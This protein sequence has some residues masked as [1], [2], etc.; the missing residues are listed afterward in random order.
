M[1]HGLYWPAVRGREPSDH[2]LPNPSN[3]RAR[4]GRTI[5]W[6]CFRSSHR[7]GALWFIL[8]YY[9]IMEATRKTHRL[10]VSLPTRLAKR[11]KSLSN[12]RRE[13]A[14]RVLVD[15]I[16]RGLGAKER[17]KELFFLLANRLGESTDPAERERLKK[18]LARMTF[19]K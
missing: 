11:V 16:E 19:G 13:S 4:G 5:A 8:V 6:Q 1:A 10:S 9:R 14:N 17:E 7:F 15:L 18:E 2:G 3:G 12:S